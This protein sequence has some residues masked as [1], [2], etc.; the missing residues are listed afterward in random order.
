MQCKFITLYILLLFSTSI[1]QNVDSLKTVL[2]ELR[3]EKRNLD[4]RIERINQTVDSLENEVRFKNLIRTSSVPYKVIAKKIIRLK[5]NPDILDNISTIYPGD[6]LKVFPTFVG[7]YA[8]ASHRGKNG[9]VWIKS[10]NL[11]DSA[12]DSLFAQYNHFREGLTIEE[13]MRER[14]REKALRDWVKTYEQSKL[15]YAEALRKNNIPL[16]VV[17]LGPSDPNSVGGV[18]CSIRVQYINKKT[19]KY[20]LF[21]FEPYNAVGDKVSCR[22]SD[23]EFLYGSVTGPIKPNAGRDDHY[24]GTA[25]YNN[26]ISCIKLVRID[27]EYM[28]GTKDYFVND[29]PKMFYRIKN[30]CS[31]KG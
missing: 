25:W 23:D 2:N 29:L 31:Y 15:E 26:T 28:D 1:C 16:Y 8:R 22:I 24:W 11:K 18:D 19:I 5:K 12:P 6:S 7:D 21:K 13:G 30:D 10:I 3:E 27:V 4:I 20:I 9:Y 14:Q 17:S